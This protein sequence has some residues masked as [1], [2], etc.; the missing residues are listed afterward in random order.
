MGSEVSMGHLIQTDGPLYFIGTG[1]EGDSYSKYMFLGPDFLSVFDGSGISLRLFLEWTAEG[2]EELP[3]FAGNRSDFAA[4]PHRDSLLI[5]GGVGVD[6]VPLATCEAFDRRGR[7][8]EA[9]PALTRPRASFA[10]LALRDGT[11]VAWGGFGSEPYPAVASARKHTFKGREGCCGVQVGRSVE[12][13]RPGRR[14]WEASP[15]PL[16]RAFLGGT[17]TLM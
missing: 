4:A 6:A 14:G 2:W 7:H 1:N 8:W 13:W 9:A 11:L 3:P 5:C 15:T 17:A 12:L 16:P 10:L